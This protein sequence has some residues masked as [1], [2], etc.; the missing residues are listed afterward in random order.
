MTTLETLAHELRQPLSAI[1]SNAQA[2]QRLLAGGGRATGEV[3]EILED[4]VACD[5]R[6]AALL[7]HLEEALRASAH[8]SASPPSSTLRQS[9]GEPV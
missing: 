1:L 2:A 4:I 5:K 7:G 6:A 9:Q 8:A 3:R